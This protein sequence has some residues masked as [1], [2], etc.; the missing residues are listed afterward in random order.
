ML[1]EAADK[2]GLTGKENKGYEQEVVDTGAA[3]E[4][5]TSTTALKN[6]A[7]ESRSPYVSVIALLRCRTPLTG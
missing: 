1:G 2:L 3:K 6:R 7:A 5:V 4:D